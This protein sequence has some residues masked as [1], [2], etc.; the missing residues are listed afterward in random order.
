MK[1]SEIIAAIESVAPRYLQESY[2]NSGLLTG[3]SDGEVGS[4][5]LSLDCTE[6]VVMEAVQKNCGLIIAHHPILFTGTKNLRPDNYVNRALIAAIKN[7]IAIYACHTNL[8]NVIT[9]VNGKIAQKLGLKNSRILLPKPDLWQK[10]SVFAPDTHA[11]QVRDA[12][13]AAGAGLIGDYKECSFNTKGTG[14]YFPMENAH[15]F[16]GSKGKRHEE[17]EQKIEV[18]VPVYHAREVV[19]AMLRAHPYEE[20][21][22]DLYFLKNET[23]HTGS[24]L[25]GDL[26]GPMSSHEFLS[27]LKEKMELPL[28]RYTDLSGKSIE[29]VALCGGAGSFLTRH[30]LAAGAHAYIT[31]DV[32]YHEF[33]D[34]ETRMLLCDIGHFESEKYTIEVFK[35]ILSENLPNFATIFSTA[36]TNPVR[37]FT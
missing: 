3:S 2:D 23:R 5:L 16:A 21:A 12:M 6:E 26:P 1:I 13:F 35:E 4:A 33:F 29:R 8:D 20:V 25:I 28:V 22:Y 17:P 36:I 27:Y 32:K 24:G 14:T 7:D 18:I 30:A 11:D 31:A 37:Y 34:A 10:L 19:E 9:G 15:P